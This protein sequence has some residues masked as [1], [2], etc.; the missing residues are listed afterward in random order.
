MPASMSVDTESPGG[1]RSGRGFETE[2]GIVFRVIAVYNYLGGETVEVE[3]VSVPGEVGGLTGGGNS[4]LAESTVSSA[5][6][7]I[8]ENPS[9]QEIYAVLAKLANRYGVPLRALRALIGTESTFRQFDSEGQPLISPN[10]KSSAAGLGQ[11]TALTAKRY[12]FD[13]NRIKTDWKYNLNV[14]ADIYKYGYD[15]PWN[16]KISDLRIRAARAYDVYHSG[17][18]ILHNVPA[19]TG[20][21]WES[22]YLTWYDRF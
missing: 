6:A 1:F 10:P 8:G 19:L 13:Y 17:P 22:L 14:A 16:S 2:N 18:Y 5:E 20:A 7:H 9:R 4:P 15:H 11:I 21:P 3:I 12:G